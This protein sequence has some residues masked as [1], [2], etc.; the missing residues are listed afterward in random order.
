MIP[1][2]KAAA[3]TRNLSILA[4]TYFAASTA[5]AYWSGLEFNKSHS[6]MRARDSKR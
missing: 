4:T 2:I 6:L 3:N 1:T 5:L